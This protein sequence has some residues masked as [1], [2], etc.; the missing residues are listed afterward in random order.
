MHQHQQ[1][2]TELENTPS[3]ESAEDESSTANNEPH[4]GYAVI[5]RRIDPKTREQYIE[6]ATT[7]AVDAFYGQLHQKRSSLSQ[8][9]SKLEALRHEMIST[10]KEMG[11]TQAELRRLETIEPHLREQ[12]TSEKTETFAHEWEEICQMRGI[13]AL[14]IEDD[15]IRARIEARVPYQSTIYDFGDFLVTFRI[16]SGSSLSCNE[17][18]SGVFTHS[19]AVYRIGKSAFCFGD[20]DSEIQEHIG[21]CQIC[22]ALALIVDC[23]HAVN[24]EHESLIP[25]TYYEAKKEEVGHEG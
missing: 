8:H 15:R 23:I 13:V 16:G 22:A 11:E 2:A 14:E 10:Q 25:A 6:F 17:I 18:R 24:K 5:K 12:I 19:D 1:L 3:A 9:Q 21:N 4:I 7:G 20:R